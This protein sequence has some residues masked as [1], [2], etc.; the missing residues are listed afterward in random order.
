MAQ[1][2]LRQEWEQ[3]L[4]A[5]H[6]CGQSSSAWCAQQH[7]NLQQFHYWKRKFAAGSAGTRSGC[8]GNTFRWPMA[9]PQ[10]TAVQAAKALH[11]S[12]A[13]KRRQA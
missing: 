5:F 9:S 2:G 7:V 13:L 3:R 4:A 1:T 11:V 8:P 6:A 12:R 10:N